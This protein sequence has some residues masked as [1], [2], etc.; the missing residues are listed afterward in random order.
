MRSPFFL[1]LASSALL[2]PSLSRAEEP[3]QVRLTEEVVVSAVR[4]EEESAVVKTDLPLAE[5]RVKNDGR[6]LAYLLRE[7]PG[8]TF[9][10]ETG[11]GAGYSYFQ[12]RGLGQS[13]VNMTLDGVP[14]NDP[15]ESAVY[16]ANF[17]D[18]ASAL[19]SVQV[20][21]GVG[22]SSF[23]AA[24][25][26]GSVNF[27]ST[28]LKERFETDATLGVGSF[29]TRRA[30]VE[31]QT[32][33]FGPGIAAWG[34]FS[35]Q[36]TDGFRDR[37]GVKQQTFYGGASWQ[38][39]S[40]F[41]KFFGFTG[42]ERSE[43]AYLAVERD[44]L[45]TDLRANPM[46]EGSTDRYRQD[47]AQLTVSH[48]FGAAT[49]TAQLY[50]NGAWGA[51]KLWDDPV[52]RNQLVSYGLDGSSAGAIVTASGRLGGFDLTGGAQGSLFSRDHFADD[53][54][55]RLYLNT[56]KK[57]EASA[58]LKV[59]RALGRL[60]L[61]V[62]AQVRTARFSTEDD[63]GTGGAEGSTRWS[64]FNPKLGARWKAD[65][66]TSLWLS[67]GTTGR[68]PSRTD[69]FAGNDDPRGPSD[70]TAVRPER[71]WDVEAGVDVKGRD[72]DLSA[73]VYLMEFRDEIA[74]TG[75]LS[76]FGS[77]IRRNVPRSYRRGLEADARWRALT[78][79]RFRL[80]ANVSWNRISE[81]TQYYD[82]YDAD[83]NPAGQTA[84]TFTG[85]EPLLTPRVTLSLSAEGEPVRSLAIGLSGRWVSSSWLDNTN[86]G[87]LAT[88]SFLDLSA[89]A[90][91][92]LSSW[93]PVGVPRLRLAVNNLLNR[94][95]IWPSGYSYLYA[96]KGAAGGESLSGAAYFYPQA[97]RSAV[98]NLDVRF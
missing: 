13:R 41:V 26:A 60:T 80:G 90:T 36:E 11:S 40:T 76:P 1:L 30:S 98:L 25:F 31:V 16:F 14:L 55:G 46:P 64:F 53:V 15:E 21:R 69:L 34:R 38:D 2:L 71:V 88:P 28:E 57:E 3:P 93:I 56:G 89:T 85:V 42:L 33:R 58:F 68:E 91:L 87:D 48:L 94:T 44:V 23:G 50:Y 4:A 47:F 17:G 35:L 73:G 19:D 97:T 54:T 77:P 84:R 43:L 24:S 96:T 59:S 49:V 52:Q 83:G 45:E 82:V 92:D 62:D 12:L 37:S 51:L 6:E 72:V 75:E 81:W 63:L 10:S 79:L 9:Y 66:A 70:L 29:G 5:I 78:N 86:T 39:E 18:F 27:A 67:L 95:T 32:G 20:Q 74:A 7:V 8:A 65:E 61:S 22:T